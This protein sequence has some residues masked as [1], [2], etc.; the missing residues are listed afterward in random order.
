MA[1]DL[2]R[3]VKQ[4]TGQ[5]PGAPASA[6]AAPIDLSRIDPAI[7]RV[8]AGGE[9]HGPYTLGQIQ[10]FAIEGRLHAASR[11][12]GGD[13]QPFLPIRDM[14]RLAEALAPAFA[15]R[16]R[17]RAEAANYLITARA[18]APAEAALWRDLPA[19]L[20]TLG[21]HMQP[22]P[23]T[24]LLRSARSLS[25]VRA[26]LAEALPKTAQ[27]FVLQTREAR[28]GW[29]GFEEDMAEAVRPVWNAPLS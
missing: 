9:V 25:E 15:E 26:T 19:C 27:V 2:G 5:A 28:L 14:P 10:Q 1:D 13:D 16:A 7:W 29:V 6:A 24:F 20:D 11:I 18:P 3:R 12:S 17:R 8:L 22:I 4:V 21:K 23:G